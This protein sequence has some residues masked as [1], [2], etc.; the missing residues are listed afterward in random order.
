MV[1]IQKPTGAASLATWFL[2]E[3][4][5][6]YRRPMVGT[7]PQQRGR[8]IGEPILNSLPGMVEHINH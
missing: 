7:P 2:V 8:V 1:N 6:A 5:S 3:M 4:E